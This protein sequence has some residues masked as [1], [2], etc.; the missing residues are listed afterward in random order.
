MD[1]HLR[2][3]S[4]GVFTLILRV[5]LI[6]DC[7]IRPVTFL[8]VLLLQL[9]YV[10]Y[11]RRDFDVFEDIGIMQWVVVYDVFFLEGFTEI[12]AIV[13]DFVGDDESLGR[14]KL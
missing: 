3:I 1:A 7:T 13:D 10:G 2:E 9:L 6:D 11:V 4:L 12:Y 14:E 5:H 8:P